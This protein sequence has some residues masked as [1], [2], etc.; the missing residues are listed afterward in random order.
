MCCSNKSIEN[1]I[2]SNYDGAKMVV[3]A[4]APEM[5]VTE[6]NIQFLAS[7]FGAP[8]MEDFVDI[9]VDNRNPNFDNEYLNLDG[10][11][12]SEVATQLKAKDQK[13]KDRRAKIKNIFGGLLNG[14]GAMVQSMG[15]QS[16]EIIYQNS[17]TPTEPKKDNTFLYVGIAVGVLVLLMT[18]FFISKKK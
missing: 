12:P 2:I 13:K 18:V 11:N 8:F 6:E 9:A 3:E 16:P 17:T 7:Y 5:P 1:A 14:A 15:P 4:Y 10:E